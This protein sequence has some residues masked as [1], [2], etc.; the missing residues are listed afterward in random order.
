M[1][2]Q[3]LL[4]R[5]RP[6]RSSSQGDHRDE[7]ERDYDRAIFSNPVKR[8]QDKAQV[9][10]LDPCD[11]V[12]TRL[13]HSHEVACV[14]RGLARKIAAKL[15]SDREIVSETGRCLETIAATT[16]VIHDLGNP[17]FGHAGERAIQ[18]WFNE[19]FTEQELRELLDGH[20]QCVLDFLNFDGNA[21]TLRLLSK[22]QVLSDFHGLNMTFG[23]LSASRKYI[24]SSL[25]IN[26][27]DH[28]RSKIGFF[29][30]E[31]DLVR[32]IEQKTGTIDARNPL[33]VI[34]EAADDIVNSVVDIEDAI[35]KRIFSWRSFDE[36]LQDRLHDSR[37]QYEEVMKRKDRILA[38]GRHHAPSD[39]P[40]DAHAAAFRTA[41]IGILVESCFDHFFFNYDSIMEGE[42]SG[43][44]IA[45]QGQ[46]HP[47]VSATKAITTEIVFKNENVL[48]LEVMGY[49]V[50]SDLLSVFWKAAK[51]Y[52]T[53]GSM[54][55]KNFSGKISG[56]LSP[57]YVQVFQHSLAN[58]NN[59]PENYFRLQLITDY[60][61]GMT[62]TF[63]KRLH[64][65]I[66]NG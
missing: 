11:S 13:T 56:L 59:L 28:S 15:I 49:R 32:K 53:K 35:K 44:L 26:T 54:G 63:A 14:A 55:T 2:W 29:A 25:D 4:N 58:N 42:F 52:P 30:S 16:A 23:T 34:V 46:V 19:N 22:L 3:S 57:N 43:E 31:S 60:V 24:C 45:R 27:E 20:E 62:D 36:M 6:R 47:L 5:D 1:D 7:F 41:S 64:A 12:R 40:P 9:F 39:L 8:L 50:I 61:C 66:Q 33:A 17:P 18:Q 10:P 38:A 21:Q 37:D 48:K 51:D 65:E